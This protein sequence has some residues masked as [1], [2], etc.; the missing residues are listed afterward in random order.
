MREKAVHVLLVEKDHRVTEPAACAH[1]SLRPCHDAAAAAADALA[2][3]GDAVVV[4]LRAADGVRLQLA[5]ENP[6]F[7]TNAA[8]VAAVAAQRVLHGVRI[9]DVTVVSATRSN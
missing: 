6:V 1:G 7:H 4:V 2:H 5:L 8:A 9:V 3:A